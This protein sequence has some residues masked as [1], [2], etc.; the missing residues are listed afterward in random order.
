MLDP[1]KEYQYRNG[2]KPWRIIW[3]VPS[4]ALPIVSICNKG[5]ALCHK[6]NG[7]FLHHDYSQWDLIEVKPKIKGYVN[8]Y[9]DRNND[10]FLGS[11]LKTKEHCDRQVHSEDRIACIEIEFEEGEG[12][13]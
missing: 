4:I 9:K 10:I 3:D 5:D 12:L 7:S 8:V 1:T 6:P 13:W 2:E 11:F